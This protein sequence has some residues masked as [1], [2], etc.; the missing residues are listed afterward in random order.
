MSRQL[1]PNH[2]PLSEAA[3]I[4]GIKQVAADMIYACFAHKSSKEII[5]NAIIKMES[6]RNGDVKSVEVSDALQ[7][8]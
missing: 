5:R 3:A 1:N 6:I 2:R 7:D 8:N 4:A